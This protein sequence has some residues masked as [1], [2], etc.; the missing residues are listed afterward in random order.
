M[1]KTAPVLF[2]LLSGF[3]SLLLQAQ[4]TALKS[5]AL[6]AGCSSQSA[7]YSLNFDRVFKRGAGRAWTYRLGVSLESSAYSGLLGG[8]LLVGGGNHLGEVSL[9]GVVSVERDK[10]AGTG[11]VDSDTYLFIIPAAGYRYQRRAGGLFARLLAGPF[12][13]ID[14]P[15]DHFFRMRG[16]VFGV[17]QAGVGWSF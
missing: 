13:R 12:I 8:S 4:E 11:V 10:N 1:L 16:R 15:S 7:L 9:D 17:V 6:F 14:P 5:N 3:F 2:I